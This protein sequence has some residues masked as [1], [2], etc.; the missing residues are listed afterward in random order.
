MYSM[1]GQSLL[2]NGR[3]DEAL[4]AFDQALVF[5]RGQAGLDDEG[6]ASLF[7]IVA[8]T[9][10]AKGDSQKADEAF[11]AAV[12]S[13]EGAIARTPA[14]KE[15]YTVR[16]QATLLRYSNYKRVIGQPA[17][18]DALKAKVDGLPKPT[19]RPENV[20]TMRVI[21]GVRCTGPYANYFTQDD[22]R[23]IRAIMPKGAPPL[24]LVISVGQYSGN[25]W[26]AD[27]YLEP[28][29]TTSEVRMG[30]VAGISTVLSAENVLTGPKMWKQ[31]VRIM[32]YVQTPLKGSDPLDV[33]SEWHPNR[34][35][36]SSA[37]GDLPLLT[38]EEVM[39]VL[40]FVRGRAVKAGST[41]R[42]ST[43]VQPWLIS[44]ITRWSP[45]EVWVSLVEPTGRR[46]QTI[47]L[48]RDGA[49]WTI[50][51]LQ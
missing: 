50:R 18:A 51:E 19:A 48:L 41:P 46:E 15:Q 5:R 1:H 38:D 34:P 10:A 16:L 49:S 13:Y 31:D 37:M 4:K 14:F 32:A 35:A 12:K 36:E 43:D 6:M 2:T 9:Q 21:D 30:R 26:R 8:V 44:R 27:A 20:S 45:T 24:W 17:A 39:S 33:A 25:T 3:F 11:A 29:R 42:L 22:I 7:E 28:D 40:T 47:R 23:Q